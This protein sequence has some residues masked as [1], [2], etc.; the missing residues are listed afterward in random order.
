MGQNGLEFVTTYP[1]ECSP[2]IQKDILLKSMPLGAKDG[3]FISAIINLPIVMSS[4]VFSVPT[5]K[6]RDNIASLLVAFDSMQY[7]PEIIQLNFSKILNALKKQPHFNIQI[8]TELAPKI[9]DGI[10]NA[11]NIKITLKHTIIKLD[12]N[13]LY[14]KNKKDKVSAFKKDLWS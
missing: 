8:L 10:Y 1:N 9:F 6:G 7:N 11:I 13:E 5:N 4:I 2:D 12:F 3:D 14:L